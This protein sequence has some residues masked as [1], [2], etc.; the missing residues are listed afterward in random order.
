MATLTIR[1]VPENV[2]E[3]LKVRA[4]NNG[5]SM[6][7]EVRELIERSVDRRM[8]WIRS[9][10]RGLGRHADPPQRR[11]TEP[12]KKDA[13]LGRSIKSGLAVYDSLFDEL[14][15]REGIPLA[16]FDAKVLKAFPKI[17]RQPGAIVSN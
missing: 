6:E 12:L 11:S 5:H 9:R 13:I 7:Q 17:A 14:A 1:N 3:L 4:K 16:T 15:D 8:F 2:V 10:S